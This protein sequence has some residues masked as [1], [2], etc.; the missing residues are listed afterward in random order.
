MRFE[1]RLPSLGDGISSICLTTYEAFLNF[2][3]FVLLQC[4]QMCGQIAVRN[5]NKRLQVIEI[6]L[7]SDHQ[8]THDTDAYAAV[9]YLI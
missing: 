4:L 6:Q 9:E 2:Y 8:S 7:L 3:E 5:I 1:C